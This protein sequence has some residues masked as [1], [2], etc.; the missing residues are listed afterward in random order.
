MATL[1]I[2]I[3][4]AVIGKFIYDTYLT[5]NAEKNWEKY[6]EEYPLDAAK[7]DLE[8]QKLN[9]LQA[10]A[11]F[12]ESKSYFS[13]DREKCKSLLEKALS[14]FPD[15]KEYLSV[16]GE[17]CRLIKVSS[18]SNANLLSH[19][20]QELIQFVELM[21]RAKF[22]DGDRDSFILMTEPKKDYN[23]LIKSA[24]NEY[25]VFFLEKKG[26]EYIFSITE[27]T[28][29]DNGKNLKDVLLKKYIRK[30]ITVE[31]LRLLLL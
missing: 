27:V 30:E 13:T 19:S 11:Y 16:H 10:N 6:R 1:L 8:E 2:V 26:D 25:S 29:F 31:E 9:L 14:L 7:I 5:N 20:F 17:V 24:S 3:V 21:F 4:I 18:T 12:N 15:N 28:D 22:I 23:P